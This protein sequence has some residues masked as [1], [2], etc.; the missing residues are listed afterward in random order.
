M[1]INDRYPLLDVLDTLDEHIRIK[2]GKVYFAYI[3][4]PGVNVSIDH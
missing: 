2:S 3:M 1:E 4:L